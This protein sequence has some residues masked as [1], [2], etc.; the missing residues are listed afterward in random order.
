MHLD[1]TVRRT[2]ERYGM[3]EDCRGL[4]LAVSGGS[5]SMAMLRWYAERSL[6]FSV[7]VAHVH[8][9]LRKDS[10]EEAE[11]V[12]DFCAQKGIPLR[13]CHLQVRD[14]RRKG[15]TTESAARRLRYEFFRA[16]AKEREATHIATGHTENDQAETVLLHL[17]HGAGPR[18]L[19]GIRPLRKEG[20]LTLIRPLL[21]VKKEE[22]EA[23]CR[24]NGVPY[25]E[26][27]S[28]RDPIYTRNRI[29]HEIL[30]A[31]EKI[32]PR[33]T[34]A[35]ARTA[36][37]LRKQ[38][39]AAEERADRFLAKEGT[40]LSKTS[41]TK[42]PE[43]DRAEVFRRLFFHR[44][45]ILSAEQ[46]GQALALLK[47]EEGSVE[48]D[49]RWIL[50]LGQGLLTLQDKRELPQ[51]EPIPV[52]EEETVLP[53]GRCLRLI[54]VTVTEENRRHTVERKLPLVLRH[55]KNGD[56]I[57]T[58][59]GTR[60]LAKILAEKK[61]PSPERDRLWV[62]TDGETL[63]WCEKAEIR[64]KNEPETGKQAYFVLLSGQ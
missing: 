4:I 6:P 35:L 8:H 39:D 38:Q 7:T 43:G 48:F 19:C 16:V 40:S 22:T 61:I 51:D 64:R 46:T 27:P 62:L 53:D 26:D 14:A 49:R 56:K 1:E 47:K 11:M 45:K 30:P 34:E 44:G 36:E 58:A 3:E 37:A 10:D 2:V 63:L 28:N 55:R 41:L 12:K 54:P 18:G 32:N 15:E 24:E 42:L 9:G 20:E 31:L 33:I 29:R 50:H 13:I 17:I 57:T 5:D 21:A 52:A 60:P 59:A 23:Y 25:A